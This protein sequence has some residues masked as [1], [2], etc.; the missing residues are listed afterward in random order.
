MIRGMHELPET[1]GIRKHELIYLVGAEEHPEVKMARS[2]YDEIFDTDK[3][4]LVDKFEIMCLICLVSSLATEDKIG[5]F[6]DLFNFNE[7]G[8]LLESEM[9]LLMMAISRGV[10]KVDQKFLPPVL[11]IVQKIAKESFKYAKLD[12]TQLRKPDLVRFVI[13]NGEISSFLECWRGHASQVL[14]PEGMKF[15]DLSF[16]A[17]ISSI[18]PTSYWAKLGLPP[19]NFV[20]WR[21]LEDVGTELGCDHLFAHQTSFLKTYDR[22]VTYT[23]DGILG[24][25]FIKQGMLADGWF[26]NALSM[27]SGKPEILLNSFVMTGPG[28]GQGTS[29]GENDWERVGKDKHTRTLACRP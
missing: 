7:K 9:V 13:S 21:R 11:R 17:N 25:G 20:H 14:I 18:I 29:L 4:G 6:F 10:F 16:P 22:R 1:F 8:Y 3:N 28:M 24:R 5:F 15:R 27:V 2:L 23:G 12:P 19:T 26:L